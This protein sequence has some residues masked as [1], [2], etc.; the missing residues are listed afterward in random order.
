[1]SIT[2]TS[3]QKTY[4]QIGCICVMLA[5]AMY[6]LAL[7]TLASPLL[8]SMNALEYVSLFSIASVLGI[9]IMT[10]VGGKLGDLIGR[11]NIVIYPG[12]LCILAG[13]GIAFVRSLIPLLILLFILG[14]AQGAFTAAPFIIVGLINERKDVPKMMG[15]LS[16]AVSAGGFLGSILAGFLTDFDLLEVAILVPALPLFAGILLIGLNFPN[17]KQE[18]HISIDG[19]G[20]LLLVITLC[21]F[22]ISLNFTPTLGLFHPLIL[23]GFATGILGLILFIRVESRNN[24]PLIPLKLFKNPNYSVL[25]LI[26]FSCYFYQ[27]AMNVYAPIAALNVLG[28]STSVAGSL[29]FPRTILTIF[30]PALFG[31]WAGKSTKNL[32]K[33]M[34]YAGLVVGISMLLLGC[35]TPDTSILLYYFAITLTGLAESFRS[36]SVTPA[37]QMALPPEEIGIG[38]SLFSFATALSSTV[39]AALYGAIYNANIAADPADSLLMQNG[40]NAVFIFA[41]VVS[42]AGAVL[43]IFVAR[44]KFNKKKDIV[45]N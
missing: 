18:G 9:A 30:L 43:A 36:V 17:K 16:A 13:V 39:S 37:A 28:T 31:V 2:L 35:T 14:L 44:A 32:W 5:I 42:F 40:V 4:V 27:T 38:T 3:R 26:G 25:L 29:Q 20:T 41:S 10:P 8:S 7:S 15:I 23:L 6:G 11:R 24:E 45:S 21:G 1:M 12:I 19:I 33:C 22:L 34:I